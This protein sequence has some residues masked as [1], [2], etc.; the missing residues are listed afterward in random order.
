MTAW[1][2]VI[3]SG[4]QGERLGGVRKADLRL[5]GQRLI[6]RVATRLGPMASL[7]IATG[8]EAAAYV[9]P[10]GAQGIADLDVPLGGPL[11]GLVAA[12]AALQRE[13]ITEGLL[14]TVAVD[15]PFLPESMASLLGAALDGGNCAYASWQ[16]Q[17]YP[18]HAVWRLQALRQ[19]PES[20]L[21]GA[22]PH[23]L[24]ALQAQVAA[25]TLDWYGLAAENPFVGVNGV[26]DL[27]SLGSRLKRGA[28]S[29]LIHMRGN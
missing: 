6:D 14:V 28:L 25:R 7:M 12:V 17:I 8:R 26:S 16:G 5:G 15:T 10:A 2:G 21:N 18:T 22:A 3:F 13:G 19:L 11:A 24:R 27:V 9:L 23:S 29:P 1:H 4:G 20:V